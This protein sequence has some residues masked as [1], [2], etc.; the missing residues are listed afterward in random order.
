[1]GIESS[2]ST[3]NF[4]GV[5][6]DF[7]M[8]LRVGGKKVVVGKYVASHQNELDWVQDEQ[9]TGE[10]LMDPDVPGTGEGLQD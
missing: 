8:I 9:G 7:E 2:S 3:A 1:L 10:G 5:N 6:L 4:E